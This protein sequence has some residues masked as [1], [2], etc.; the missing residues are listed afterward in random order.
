MGHLL[1]DC[2][3]RDLALDQCRE[4]RARLLRQLTLA[5]ILLGEVYS[6]TRFFA[7]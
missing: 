2:H 5:A 6:A 3:S 7:G 1:L 4:Q